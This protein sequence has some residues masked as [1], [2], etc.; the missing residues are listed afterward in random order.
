MRRSVGWATATAWLLWVGANALGF[1]E[2]WEL[3]RSFA[4]KPG[5]TLV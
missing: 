2:G 4:R 5:S 1:M 3:G